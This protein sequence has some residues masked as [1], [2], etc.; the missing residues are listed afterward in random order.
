MTIR[1]ARGGLV[2]QF[3]DD[4]AVRSVGRRDGHRGNPLIK[5]INPQVALVPIESKVRARDLCP[6]RASVR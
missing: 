3:I 5:G 2:E 1:C 4:L 6:W